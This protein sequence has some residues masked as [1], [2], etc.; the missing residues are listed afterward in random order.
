MKAEQLKQYIR[1][2]VKEQVDLRT[3]EGRELKDMMTK[4]LDKQ[5]ELEAFNAAMQG[6]LARQ[7]EIQGELGMAHKVLFGRMEEIE[8]KTLQIENTVAE[9]VESPKFSRV[10]PGYKELYDQAVATLSRFSQEQSNL[11]EASKAAQIAA[12]RAEKKRELK[13]STVQTEQF[14][15]M[16]NKFGG[17]FKKLVAFLF[18]KTKSA[19][20]AADDA[21]NSLNA[22]KAAV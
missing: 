6:L 15:P 16:K 3:K 18:G 21:L 17:M 7:K 22:L 19:L 11:I 14:E 4:V 13:F 20:N 10:E 9:I 1:K 12:K 2:V 5:R 8:Q